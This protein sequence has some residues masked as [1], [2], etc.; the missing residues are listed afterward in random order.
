MEALAFVCMEVGRQQ[1][2]QQ[3]QQ[4]QQQQQ[5]IACEYN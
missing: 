4:Q 3:Q 2:P 1:Q 5:E